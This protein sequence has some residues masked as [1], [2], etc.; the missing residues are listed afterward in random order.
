MRYFTSNSTDHCQNGSPSLLA[1]YRRQYQLAWAVVAY[2]WPAFSATNRTNHA[3]PSFVGQA[4]VFQ[5]HTPC[6][7]RE[8]CDTEVDG[9]EDLELV[10]SAHKPAS[11]RPK[12]FASLKNAP[13]TLPVCHSSL[14]LVR[15]KRTVGKDHASDTSRFAT[16]IL[17]H[18]GAALP[19]LVGDRV[20]LHRRRI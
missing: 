16:M 4:Q 17:A 1:P 11:S 14:A 15:K 5:D 19:S 20:A 7:N 3:Q 18:K 6:R 13:G 9:V 2:P 12:H 8:N 10:K